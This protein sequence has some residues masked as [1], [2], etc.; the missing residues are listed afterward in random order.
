LDRL[1]LLGDR[2]DGLSWS[3]IAW[4][5]WDGIGMTRGS[6]YRA[7]ADQ[8]GLSGLTAEDGQDAFRQ[9]LAGRTHSA[10]NVPI[11]DSEHVK[12]GV[13]VIP[14][15]RQHTVGR[16]IE[17]GVELATI[18]CLA[19]HKVR[20]TPTLPGAW[21]LDRMVN[22]GL[23]LI[24]N[25]AT[26]AAVTIEDV[27]FSRFVR[28]SNDKEPNM[29]VVAE[30][31]ADGIVTWM[32][33]DVLHPS[34][35]TLSKDLVFAQAT[36]RFEVEEAAGERPLLRRLGMNNGLVVKR[37]VDDP[38]CNGRCGDVELSGPFDCVRDIAI[39]CNGRQA[40]FVPHQ[41]RDCPGVI[42]AMLLD[43]AWRVGAMYAVPGQDAL[44]VPVRI[45]RLVIPV[46]VNA[47]SSSASGWEIHTTAPKVEDG[48]VRWDRTEVVDQVGSL[49]LIV[50]DTFAIRIQ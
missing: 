1:C 28:Y 39:G 29:R 24:D 36:L 32:I 4:L 48:D 18:D 23:Q 5:A 26:L 46:G 8:R 22:A 17:V 9:V 34:G 45:R 6:E 13:N 30:E 3:S 25:V 14:A 37:F 12:Y 10:V 27:S 50:E 40:R 2:H 15:L 41:T 20:K 33:G 38:Y 19:C 49:K 42:P 16:V 7:L 35:F 44:Y 31:T 21:I 47:S 11:S 43:S